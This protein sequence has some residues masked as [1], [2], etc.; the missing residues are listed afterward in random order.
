MMPGDCFTI[1]P[2]LIQGLNPQGWCF[3]DGWTTSTEN[4]A[5]SAQAEH[6]VLI[7]E[8]GADVITE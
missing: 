6:M 2:C 5:R 3:P 7:T 4:G 1:E 8:D